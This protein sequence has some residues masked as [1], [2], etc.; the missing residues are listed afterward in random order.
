MGKLIAFAPAVTVNTAVGTAT[1]NIHSIIAAVS[2]Q[3]SLS[4]NKMHIDVS[5]ICFIIA[6]SL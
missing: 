4:L 3:Y 5:A 1:V 6:L 2:G